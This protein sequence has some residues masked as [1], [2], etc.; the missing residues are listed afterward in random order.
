M[1]ELT[2]FDEFVDTILSGE[3]VEVEFD[4]GVTLTADLEKI[5]ITVE[6]D[7]EILD[8]VLTGDERDFLHLILE[9]MFAAEKQVQAVNWDEFPIGNQ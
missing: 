1:S 4:S 8:I 2:I 6:D 9:A 3:I 7:D 5:G